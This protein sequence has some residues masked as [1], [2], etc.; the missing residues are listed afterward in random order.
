MRIP[1]RIHFIH[2][3]YATNSHLGPFY[4]SGQSP[5]WTDDEDDSGQGDDDDGGD[6][7]GDDGGYEEDKE[8][9][10]ASQGT[11]WVSLQDRFLGLTH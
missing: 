10:S 4:A 6:G 5:R 11:F 8:S 3:V 7:D 9:T 1:V 2:I